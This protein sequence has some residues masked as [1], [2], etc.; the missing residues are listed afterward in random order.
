MYILNMIKFIYEYKTI[1][2]IST[3]ILILDVYLNEMAYCYQK[4]FFLWDS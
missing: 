4:R 1:I 2:I 3:I